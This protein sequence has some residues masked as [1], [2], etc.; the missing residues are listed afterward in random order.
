M[1]INNIALSSNADKILET[2]D[3][4]TTYPHGTNAFRV[5]QSE[6]LKVKAK[7]LSKYKWSILMVTRMRTILN[8]I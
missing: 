4:I 6:I 3:K 8:I 7:M 5:C 1:S 2:F